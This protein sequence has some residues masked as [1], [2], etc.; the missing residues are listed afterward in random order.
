MNAGGFHVIALGTVGSTN[1][2][3]RRLAENGAGSGTVVWATEQTAGRGRRG[4]GWISPPGNLYCSVLTRPRGDAIRALQ[5]GFVTGVSLVDGLARVL[6]NEARIQC[7]WPNDVVING[8]KAAGVLLESATDG[9]GGVDWLIIGI[10]INVVSHPSTAELLYPATSLAAEGVVGIGAR[11]VLSSF[12]EAF[13]SWS[14]RWDEEGFQVI[15]SAWLERALGLDRDI[16]VRLDQETVTG[17]FVDL[18]ETGALVLAVE[19]VRRTIAAGDVFPVV[20]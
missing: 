6:A 17:R 20:A 19:G 2:E 13:A 3:L 11:A 18:D 12:L 5:L 7:K 10:G 14:R 15:R 8:R 1:D 4:R 9:A 16:V